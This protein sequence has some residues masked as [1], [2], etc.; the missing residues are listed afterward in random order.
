MNPVPWD[1]GRV[2]ACARVHVCMHVKMLMGKTSYMKL[3]AT[4]VL[5]V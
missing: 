5:T 3:K 4:V 2:C 1:W